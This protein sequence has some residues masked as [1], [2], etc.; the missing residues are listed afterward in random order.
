MPSWFRSPVRTS[1]RYLQH[2]LLHPYVWRYVQGGR[3]RSWGAKSLQESGRRGE[4][5][6]VGDGYARIGEGSGSTNLL[7]GSGVDEAWT[8][9]TQLAE[10]V[11]ELLQAGKPLSRENLE[12]AYVARRRASWVEEEAR[13]AE[14]ARDGFHNGLWRGLAGMALAGFTKGR[15]GVGGEPR[16]IP[17]LETYSPG[18]RELAADATLRA[19]PATTP[20]WT[21]AAGPLFLTTANCW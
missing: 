5:L 20:S 16:P 19:C 4:P 15:M 10:G 14:R 7:T 17:D 21:A 13:I 6:L 9:G 11:V 2:F 1:Y 12:N 18:A 8:T 3:L